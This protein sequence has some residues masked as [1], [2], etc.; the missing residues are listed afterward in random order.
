MKIL[1][2]FLSQTL[3]VPVEG[4]VRIQLNLKVEQTKN[5]AAVKDF[6]SFV[7]PVMWLEEVSYFT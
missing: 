6:R 4:K 2:I 7:F 3:G 5:I 1:W